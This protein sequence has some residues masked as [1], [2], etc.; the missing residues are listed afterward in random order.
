MRRFFSLVKVHL[1][2]VRVMKVIM[3]LCDTDPPTNP[4]STDPSPLTPPP[5]T[6]PLTPPPLTPLRQNVIRSEDP[7]PG[8]RQTSGS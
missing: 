4:P 1:C 2:E 5:L 6:P 3:L 7:G 8:I